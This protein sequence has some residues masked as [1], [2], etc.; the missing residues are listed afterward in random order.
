MSQ[1]NDS[2]KYSQIWSTV[3]KEITNA[4]YQFY[5]FW[6]ITFYEIPVPQTFAYKLTYLFFFYIYEEDV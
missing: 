1:I 2:T 3:I 4:R 5:T 6:I